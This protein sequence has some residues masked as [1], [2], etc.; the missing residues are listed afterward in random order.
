MI[1]VYKKETKEFFST[2]R[3]IHPFYKCEENFIR[4][5]GGNT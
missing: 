3:P 2:L 1:I 4:N 5:E